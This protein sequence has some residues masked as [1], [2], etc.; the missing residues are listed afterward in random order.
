[1]K[2]RRHPNNF[3]NDH[4]S[5]SFVCL[6][7]RILVERMKPNS[8]R[9]LHRSSKYRAILRAANI[10]YPLLLFLTESPKYWK[11]TTYT[12][13]RQEYCTRPKKFRTEQ[14]L[15]N[16]TNTDPEAVR[17]TR[18]ST[19]GAKPLESKR[20]CR[21]NHGVRQKAGLENHTP[22]SVIFVCERG[23]GGQILKDGRRIRQ[24][25]VAVGAQRE[26][27]FTFCT[28]FCHTP[29]KNNFSLYYPPIQL[30]KKMC[31]S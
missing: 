8:E 12:K 28:A 10:G 17:L 11:R 9:R 3:G 18:G 22:R 6:F 21:L 27:K 19:C 31:S 14:T 4:T 2:S 7:F 25:G 20:N 23:G 29:V 30:L 16:G 24:R 13:Y 15:R 26:L 1:M 5:N